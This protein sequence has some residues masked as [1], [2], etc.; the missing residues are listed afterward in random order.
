MEIFIIIIWIIATLAITSIAAILGKR[1]GV[2]YLIAT[3]AALIVM[4]AI[5]ANKIVVFGPFTVP[6]GVIV[7]SMTFLITDIL[8]EKWGK[9]YARRAVWAGF[10][11]SLILVVSTYIVANWKPAPF[12]VEISD[13]FSKVVALTPRIVFASLVAYLLSQHHD[14]WAFHF[15]KKK[16]KGKYLW[17]RNNASTI[18][19]QFIDSTVFI[20]LA[21]YGIFPIW[22]LILG[23]WVVKMIIA[24]IDT[25]FLY[26]VIK[27][28][29]RIKSKE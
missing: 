23:Q 26:I 9:K 10:Y 14:V 22:P 16:T 13:M 8:S 15:W 4:A 19:S 28:I 27:L 17:F 11:A 29:D 5:F 6:A 21:F 7:F 1:Y 2:E 12:A 3:V 24:V 25:P 18:V 20:T